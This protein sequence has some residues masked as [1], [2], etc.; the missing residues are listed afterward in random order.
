MSAV[1]LFAKN[2]VEVNFNALPNN[3]VTET[4]KQILDTL[5]VIVAGSM[6]KNI[7]QLV[8][9]VKEWG[10][11]EEST[12]LGYGGKVP[13]VNAALINGWS[14]AVLDYDDFHDLDFIHSSRE[15]V[16][17]SLAVAERKGGVS[18]NDFIVAVVL[19]S[20]LAYRMVRAVIVHRE[21]GFLT[22]PNFFGVAAAVSKLLGLDEVKLKNALGLALMQVSGE[23]YGIREALNTNG[24]DNGFQARGGVLGALMA[25]RGL[26]GP[27]DPIEGRGFGFYAL[28]HRNLYNSTLLTVDLGKVFENAK[29]SQKPYPGCR[30]NHAAVSATLALVNEYNIKADDV[31]EITVHVGPIA[32]SLSQPLEEKRKPRNSIHT[33]H[34]MPW[35]IANA[36]VYRKLGIEHFTEEAIRDTK[37]LEMAQKVVPKLNPELV[38]LTSVEP[39]IVE[40]KTKGG[41]V[42]SRHVD[43]APG[44]PEDPMSFS[45]VVEKFRYCCNYSAKSIS[46]D[47]QDEIIGMIE[48]LEEGPDVAQIASLLG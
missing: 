16:P 48:R 35:S 43:N 23:S 5:G 8:D 13:C 26:S 29:V 17:A 7:R 1:S 24:L 32:I 14:A 39:A 44:S 20:D 38:H 28:F 11:E 33:Q 12:I 45:D 25:E 27:T 34:S 47:I 4:K 6:S 46:Q 19:G 10:G 15:V 21:S 22:V 3:V 30:F 9:L 42:Y 31:A 2:I 40:I 41:R 37:V 36:V 18:G